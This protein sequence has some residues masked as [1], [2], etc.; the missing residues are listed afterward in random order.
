MAIE[1][2]TR[3]LC[4]VQ[5]RDGGDLTEMSAAEVKNGGQT[6]DKFLKNRAV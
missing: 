6:G 3:K 5:G 1:S 4:R 2:P